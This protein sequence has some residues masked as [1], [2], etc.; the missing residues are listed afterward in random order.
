MHKQVIGCEMKV[1]V[2]VVLLVGT[3]YSRLL[4]VSGFDEFI[5]PLVW[6]SCTTKQNQKITK[7]YMK[8]EK[9]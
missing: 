6:G 9:Y 2:N 7:G 5:V 8:P 1:I 3:Q 4:V